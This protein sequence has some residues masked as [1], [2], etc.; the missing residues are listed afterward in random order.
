MATVAVRERVSLQGLSMVSRTILL[1]FSSQT[2]MGEAGTPPTEKLT[3]G[4]S[5][6]ARP[7]PSPSTRGRPRQAAV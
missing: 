1:P 2:T 5:G 7:M 6:N 4:S 3:M